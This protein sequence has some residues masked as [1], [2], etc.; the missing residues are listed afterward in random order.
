[1]DLVG[2]ESL[3]N[4]APKYFTWLLS[5]D[6]IGLAPTK[7]LTADAKKSDKSA[8]SELKVKTEDSGSGHFE[9]FAPED[10]H[11]EWLLRSI[12]RM[13]IQLKDLTDGRQVLAHMGVCSGALL[14]K[15]AALLGCSEGST[16]HILSEAELRYALGDPILDMVVLCWGFNTK[17]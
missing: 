11:K 1:M 10:G 8:A 13:F 15:M 14:A 9:K 3:K 5:G 16:S 12:N 2:T 17:V 6:V 7:E 4:E